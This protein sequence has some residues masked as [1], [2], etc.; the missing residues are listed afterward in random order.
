ME[1][2]FLTTEEKVGDIQ[3]TSDRAAT[4][5]QVATLSEGPLYLTGE[6]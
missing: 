3:Y 5:G 1:A 6:R 4:L 2:F